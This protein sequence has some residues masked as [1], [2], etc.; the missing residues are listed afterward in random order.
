MYHVSAILPTYNEKENIK[1]LILAI[2]R[3]LVPP[4]EIIVVDD[5]SPD[6]TW[7]IVGRLQKE[8]PHL[9]LRR[10]MNERGLATA[11]RDGIAFAT[12]DVIT[13]MDC[14]FSHPPSLIPE[15]VKALDEADVVIASR[16]VRGG[17]Q[18]GPFIRDV[19]SRAFNLYARLF[20][21]TAVKDWTSGFV[22]MKR[23][24]L[25]K[26]AIEPMGQGYGEYFVGVLYGAL[27]SGF[28]IKE[29]PYT[30]VYNSEH[31][32]KTST[33]MFKLLQFGYSYGSSVL[34]LRL[35]ALKGEL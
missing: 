28:R 7:E 5:N 14:D 21:A 19:T 24:V 11:L 10:R 22:M 25:N 27:R 15:M 8:V 30:C 17:G 1:N 4:P 2:S 35:R 29:I 9:K 12:G 26:V 18:K 34:K 33:N 6:R 13:W 23:E 3:Q 32:S 16:Y 20:L 31:E